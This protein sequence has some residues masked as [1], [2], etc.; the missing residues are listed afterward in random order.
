MEPTNEQPYS[1]SEACVGDADK[2]LAL[3]QSVIGRA[4]CTWNEYY[5][6]MPQIKDDVENNNL[7][8]LR[9]DADIIGAISIVPE[10]E[11]N[12][13]DFWIM[14]DGKIAEIAR[15]AVAPEY[16]GKGLAL[17][18]VSETEKVLNSR[19]YRAVHLL[20]ALSNIPACHTYRKAGYQLLGECD[21]FGHRYCAFEKELN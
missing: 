16:Q 13:L 1:F 2:L 7:F 6:G 8:V 4:F 11:L 15:V 5:P 14:K 18:M 3:Y 12:D 19:G 9:N 17:K 20:A 10:N 21:M